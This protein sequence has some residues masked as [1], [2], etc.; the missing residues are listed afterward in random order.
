V[1]KTAIAEAIAATPAFEVEFDPTPGLR[2]DAEGR[3]SWVLWVREEDQSALKG[4]VIEFLEAVTG[5][6]QFD[7]E[8][9]RRFPRLYTESN[10][11]ARRF[12]TLRKPRSTPVRGCFRTGFLS[13]QKIGGKPG[14]S[15]CSLIGYLIAVTRG[16]SQN[17]GTANPPQR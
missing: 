12:R 14:I 17:N 11:E 1:D 6:K 10:R 16:D 3:R 8:P 2:T 15:L 5:S 9:E 13:G 4:L 7:P